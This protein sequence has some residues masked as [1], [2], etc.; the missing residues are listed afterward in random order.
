MNLAELRRDYQQAGLDE[1][2]VDADPLAQFDRWFSDALRAELPE[3]NAMTIATANA[4]GQP[5]ARIVLLK[6]YGQQGLVFFT[7]ARSRK[8]RELA[9]NPRAAPVFHWQ[10]LERQVRVV[11][12]VEQLTAD[13]STEYFA[14]R[15]VGSQLGAWASHQSE[16]IA[17]RPALERAW[18]AMAERYR[19]IVVPRPPTW[20]GY[21]VLP[22]EFEFWQGRTNR[23]HDRIS[24][25]RT[26]ES[27]WHRVRLSP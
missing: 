6:D 24:Y 4:Q 21:R 25:T 3:P 20:G 16:T 14:S 2:S 22:D 23:L 12:T 17:D 9:V 7:D 10:E 1:A 8:G 15:P 11:G 18:A 19:D 26:M 13:E 5:S 27:G